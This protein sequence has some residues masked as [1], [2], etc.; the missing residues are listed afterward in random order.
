MGLK[1]KYIKPNR[2]GSNMKE[3]RI[4]KSMKEY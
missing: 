4:I 1:P 3:N 2:K